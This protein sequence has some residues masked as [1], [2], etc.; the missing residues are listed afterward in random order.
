[1]TSGV[2]GVFLRQGADHHEE[3][4]RAFGV[5][6]EGVRPVESSVGSP[7]FSEVR[8]VSIWF[9]D[10]KRRKIST[11]TSRRLVYF[12]SNVEVI[13]NNLR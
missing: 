3:S 12:E 9:L 13:V 7:S 6:D 1:M 10:R 8:G 11:K 2:Q 5:S 4:E